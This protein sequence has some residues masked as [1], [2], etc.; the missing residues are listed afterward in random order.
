MFRLAQ[1]DS[2]IM[3]WVVAQRKE[4]GCDCGGKLDRL[5]LPL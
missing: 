3:R 1:H 5:L 2:V 4:L